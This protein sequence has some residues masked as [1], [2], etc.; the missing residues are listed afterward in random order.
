MATITGSTYWLRIFGHRLVFA[1]GGSYA[2]IAFLALI[3][4]G[5]VLPLWAIGHA[6][7]TPKWAFK[8]LGRS[9]VR[10][11]LAMAVLFLLGDLSVLL[12]AIYY[13]IRIRPQLD[14]SEHESASE[15]SE[16]VMEARHHLW[17]K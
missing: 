17:T 1:H 10:W 2:M 15:R 12:P 9:K 13:F 5:I 16:R 14:I 11:I 3:V 4:I 6:V 7:F 8:S